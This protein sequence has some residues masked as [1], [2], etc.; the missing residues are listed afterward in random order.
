MPEPGLTQ[1][2]WKK[3]ARRPVHAGPGH[4]GAA[5]PLCPGAPHPLARRRG[6]CRFGKALVYRPQGTQ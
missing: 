5:S 4:D 6:V 2:N 3:G 1:S